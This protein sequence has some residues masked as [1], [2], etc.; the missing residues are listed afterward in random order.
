VRGALVGRYRIDRK[1]GAGGM[2]E[3]Y[4]ADDIELDRKVALKFLAPGLARGRAESVRFQREARA[5]ASLDHPNIVTIH[6]VGEFEGRAFIAMAYVPGETLAEVIARGAVPIDRALEITLQICAGLA[7]AHE[8]GVVHRDIKPGNIALAAD[9]HVRILDFGLAKLDDTTVLTQQDTTVGT[10]M[11]MSPEQARGE[12][13]D[14]RADLFS[15]GALLYEMVTGR[16]AFGGEH[17]AAIHHAIAS[18]DPEPMARYTN[19]VDPELERIVRKLLAKDPTTRYQAATDVMADIRA[20]RSG[21]HASVVIPAARAPRSRWVPR[22]AVGFAVVVV[23]V[24]A[25]LIGTA[26]RGAAPGGSGEPMLAVL[27]FANL[28]EAD[29]AYFADGMTEEI[30]ARLVNVD[31]LGVISRR[32][33][34]RYRQ[35]DKPI[36]EIARELDVDYVLE[37]TVRWD[38][39]QEPERVRITPQLTRVADEVSLWAGNYEHEL[40]GVF[41]IQAEIAVQVADALDVTLRDTDHRAVNDRLTADIDAYQ[42]YLKGREQLVAPDFSRESFALG[43]RMFERAIELDPGFAVA[44]AQLSEM[45]SRMVHYGFDRSETRQALAKAAVDRAFEL[46]PDLPE[47]WLAL[48]YYHYW[49]RRDYGEALAALDVAQRLAPGMDEIVLSRAYVLRRMGDLEGSAA[50]LQDA[51]T[52]SPLDAAAT[53]SLGETYATLRRYAQAERLIQRAIDLAPDNV[54]PYTELALLHLR[55]R[56]DAAAARRALARIPS[57]PGAESCRVGHLVE[58]FAGELA[59]ARARL[60]ECPDEILEA[61]AFFRPVSLLEGLT[62]KLSGDEDPARVAL[63]RAQQQLEAR[64]A[65]DPDDF[66]ALSALGLALAGLGRAEAAVELGER[67]V[68]LYPL[69]RDALEAPVIMIDLAL[70]H[71]MVG[72]R[73]VALEL[74]DEL[75]TIPS[76]LSTAWLRHDPRWGVLGED[77]AFQALLARHEGRS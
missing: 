22:V 43:V 72:Q 29:D 60:E 32:S 6:E 44:H 69:E 27:P 3:V 62:W 36:A 64:L 24:V 23:A 58:L 28:G 39:S 49:C 5:A 74:L 35:T 18:V 10:L 4:L 59:A 12:Q 66:R 30:I 40:T 1:L 21:T 68:A 31:G 19:G 70:I 25:L 73:D 7:R 67:A 16:R 51:L 15:V 46:D 17:A 52:R 42:A 33:T 8:A 48:G 47:A 76:I 41:T 34:M 54:Y 26:D 63:S 37:G 9:G 13:V 57:A 11:Y 75:L 77:P 53:V 61:N 20:L 50:L 45:H 56:G 55:W 71:A 2:G 14:G 65:E 38:R